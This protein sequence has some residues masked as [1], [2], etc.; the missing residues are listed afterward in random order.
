[1]RGHRECSGPLFS[2]VS[3]EELI[4]AS[5][6]LRRIWKLADQ[7]YEQLNSPS[8]ELYASEGLP[9][10]PLEQLH[11]NLLFRWFV[12][13]RTDDPM[14]HSTT[15]TKNREPLFNDEIMGHSLRILMVALEV[16]PLLSDEHS[17]VDGT[18]LQT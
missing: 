12:G 5:H 18:L 7:A 3:I 10:V 15:F 13:L 11:C 8:C 9:S 4:P 16:K 14:W 1:M 2:Y 17:S 6:P